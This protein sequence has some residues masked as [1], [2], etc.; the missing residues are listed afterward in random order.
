MGK[1]LGIA[2]VL[3]ALL[4]VVADRGGQI[5]IERVVAGQLQDKLRSP[6]EPS[7]DIA[8]F[9]FLPQ[10]ITRD[11]DDVTLSVRD[12][13][14]GGVRV[15]RIDAHLLGVTQSGGGARVRNVDG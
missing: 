10:L 2:F 7:V 3:V 8:G 12:A 6:K 1:R 13:D 5:A 14:A 15:A 9:P 4:L 11:F